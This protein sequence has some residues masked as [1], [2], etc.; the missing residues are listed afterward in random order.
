MR[1]LTNFLTTL[2]SEKFCNTFS[3]LEDRRIP[4]E[5]FTGRIKATISITKIVTYNLTKRMCQ[6]INIVM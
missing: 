3:L 1:T 2:L 4:F 6:I 5:F